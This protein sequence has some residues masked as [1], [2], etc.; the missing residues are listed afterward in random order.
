M[1]T[2]LAVIALVLAP[3]LGLACPMKDGKQAMSCAE[4]HMLDS[5]TG[6]CVPQATS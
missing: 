1:K 5:Q 2:K 4:G 6:T 3:S